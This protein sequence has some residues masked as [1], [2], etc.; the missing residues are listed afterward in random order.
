MYTPGNIVAVLQPVL[1]A[2]AAHHPL[3]GARA[4][5]SLVWS[6]MFDIG[7]QAVPRVAS[8]A[9]LGAALDSMPK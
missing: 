5:C 4:Y 3:K 2:Q 7:A 1:W 9:P 8:A 6:V